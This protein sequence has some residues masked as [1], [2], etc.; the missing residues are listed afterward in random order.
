MT[1]GISPTHLGGDQRDEKCMWDIG[2][3]LAVA[4]L[5]GAAPAAPIPSEVNVALYMPTTGDSIDPISF[6]TSAAVDGIKHDFRQLFHPRRRRPAR[7]GRTAGSTTRSV[8]VGDRLDS[9]TEYD[10]DSIR[11]ADPGGYGRSDGHVADRLRRSTRQAGGAGRPWIKLRRSHTR[12]AGLKPRTPLLPASAARR[13]APKLRPP[14]GGEDPS[15]AL[16]SDGVGLCR[17]LGSSRTLSVLG[18]IYEA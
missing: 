18:F 7:H 9:S 11:V 10:L 13:S 14:I 4:V 6:P 1:N 2:G 17:P 5:A 8:R 3:C 16:T 12:S 15:M